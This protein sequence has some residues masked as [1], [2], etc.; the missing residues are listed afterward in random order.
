MTSTARSALMSRIRGRNTTPE[1]QLRSLLYGAGL[2]FRLHA[3][4]VPGRPDLVFRPSKVAVFVDGC[5]WH[6]CPRHFRMP[7]T[8]PDFWHRK[9][10]AN[11]ARRRQVRRQLLARQWK[12]IEIWECD[13]RNDATQ[14]VDLVVGAVVARRSARKSNGSK[15]E[16]L[17]HGRIPD[18]VSKRSPRRA[19]GS[20][21][22]GPRLPTRSNLRNPRLAGK[23]RRAPR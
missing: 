12:A 16:L 17:V 7:S 20:V 4:D 19:S 22:R 18:P 13:L 23:R 15:K 3:K 9:I 1:L 21:G 11:V 6:K 10:A 14:C 2:R 8:N 5:F